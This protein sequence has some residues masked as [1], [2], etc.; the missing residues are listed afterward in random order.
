[1][2]RQDLA[3]R[4]NMVDHGDLGD[5]PSPAGADKP[6]PGEQDHEV[7]ATPPTTNPELG[8]PIIANPKCS[9]YFLEPVRSLS[10]FP[11]CCYS[12]MAMDR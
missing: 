7:D 3:T 1:M 2:C 8:I 4:E 9:G 5:L 11:C 10:S 6:K 12:C